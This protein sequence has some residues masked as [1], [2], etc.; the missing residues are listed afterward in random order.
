[1]ILPGA[2]RSENVLIRRLLLLLLGTLTFWVLVAVPARALGGG[3]A[4]VVLS[5]T[6]LLLCI[7]PMAGTLAWTDWALRQGPE[8]QMVA[9]LGGTGLRMFVVLAGGWL[10][11]STV[12][13]YQQHPGF[14][15]WLVVCY[16][17][18][19]TLDMI[20]ILAGRPVSKV[21]P[22]AT[23]KTTEAPQVSPTK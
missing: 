12:P 20:L 19:L 9:V 2:S 1:M 17:F 7:V 10:L 22:D 14:W 11:H 5:G 8:R 21:E 3:N 6:A 23:G 16:L 15:M 4:A 13:Y 18:A